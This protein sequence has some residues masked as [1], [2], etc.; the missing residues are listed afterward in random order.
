MKKK[1][2]FNGLK[3]KKSIKYIF[4]F[5]LVMISILIFPSTLSRYVSFG[6]GEANIDVAFSL[7]QTEDLT[8]YV[9]LDDISPDGEYREYTIAVMNYDED[10]NRIDVN[11]R[12]SINIKTTTNLPIDYVIVDDTGNGKELT[13]VLETDEYGTIF[14]TYDCGNFVA[15]YESDTIQKYT[16]KYK[17]DNKYNTSDY[18]DVS[19]M[20]VVSIEAEQIV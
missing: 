3:F 13:G 7:L 8:E 2:R 15:T 10:G 5:I 19:E 1:L 11:M 18:Q 14:N 6:N 12:Y 16:I 9:E 20:I 17:L 4:V